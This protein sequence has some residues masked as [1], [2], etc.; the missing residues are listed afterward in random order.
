MKKHLIKIW[1]DVPG[2]QNRVYEGLV[3]GTQRGN[4]VVIDPDKLFKTA[5]GYTMPNNTVIILL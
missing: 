5:F 3:T 2:G 1:F 4:K